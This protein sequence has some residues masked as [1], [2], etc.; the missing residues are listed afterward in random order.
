MVKH[1]DS[2]APSELRAVFGRNLKNLSSSFSSVSALCRSLG[3]NRTQYNRYLTG[4]SFPRPEIL[5]RICAFFDVDARILLSPLDELNRVPGGV[6]AHPFIAE[7]LG[8]QAAQIPEDVFPSGFYRFSRRGFL[9]DRRFLQ[10]LVLI[11]RSEDHT[12]LRG[13]EPREAMRQQGLPETPARREFRGVVLRQDEGISIL[14]SRWGGKTGS[15]NFLS[16][17]ASY[18]NN[19]WEG[20]VT[21]TVRWQPSGQRMTRMVYEYL[22]RDTGAVLSAA[23]TVGYCDRGNLLPHHLRLLQVDTPM[24]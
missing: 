1:H 20:Y 18:E 16:P 15:F 10:G 5:Y 3:I 14:I 8:T 12:F 13:F 24:G 11:H 6:L 17:V 7:W 23:R 22:G 21:R 2:V 9:D 4:E 19:Y